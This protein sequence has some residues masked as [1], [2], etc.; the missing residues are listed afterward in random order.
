MNW[1]KQAQQMPT[2]E[3]IIWAIDKLIAENYEFSVEELQQASGISDSNQQWQNKAAQT[4]KTKKRLKGYPSSSKTIP[5]S[6]VK[7]AIDKKVLQLSDQ[8]MSP[9]SISKQL[10]ISFKDVSKIL[11]KYFP[12]KEDKPNYLKNKYEKNILDITKQKT[13]EMKKDFNILRI[14]VKDIASE[15][16]VVP[17]FVQKTLI[18]NNV[19]IQILTRERKDIV[20]KIIADIANSS[21]RQLTSKQIEEIFFKQYQYR[22]KTNTIIAALVMRNAGPRAR[23]NPE[24]TIF[25]ALNTFINERVQGGIKSFIGRPENLPI[26]ID[27]FFVQHGKDHGFIPPMPKEELQRMLMTKVQLLERTEENI[28]NRKNPN[29]YNPIITDKSHPSYFLNDQPADQPANQPQIQQSEDKMNW[30][31]KAKKGIP[32]GIADKKKPSDFNKKQLD[33]GGKVEMEHTRYKDLAKDIAKDH[34]EEFPNYYTEL[35]K[36]ENKLE[37]KKPARRGRYNGGL[38]RISF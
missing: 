36:M 14:N 20:G 7:D 2:I 34:L 12:N 6:K 30:Y 31:K 16:G 5:F 38:Q 37:E 13:K 19:E 22:P 24:K 25:K 28:L 33:R 10:G 23:E 11:K 21:Q 18:E 35:D 26:I 1:Y 15:L 29:R 4:V 3:D 27:K 32:G 9:T 17:Q 8:G